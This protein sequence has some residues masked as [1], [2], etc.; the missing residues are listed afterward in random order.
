MSGKPKKEQTGVLR[1]AQKQ[2]ARA[3]P[4]GNQ[5]HGCVEMALPI[6]RE[7]QSVNRKGWDN[8]SLVEEA[9]ISLSRGAEDLNS[10]GSQNKTTIKR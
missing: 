5:G 1:H 3:V 4:Q 10:V 7:D 6:I 2:G 9:R 8:G